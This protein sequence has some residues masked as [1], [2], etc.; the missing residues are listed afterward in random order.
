MAL[1]NQDKRVP[2]K[3]SSLAAKVVV[4]NLPE[5]TRTSLLQA[6]LKPTPV[7]EVFQLFEQRLSIS[8]PNVI[9]CTTPKSLYSSAITADQWYET[10][11][12]SNPTPSGFTLLYVTDNENNYIHQYRRHNGP[13]LSDLVKRPNSVAFYR[14]GGFYSDL[15]H[16]VFR[17]LQNYGMFNHF[18]TSGKIFPNSIVETQLEYDWILADGEK[19]IENVRVWFC[20]F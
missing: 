16:T 4:E 12:R 7:M 15:I 3:L 10:V 19:F 1:T 11:K 9:V 2:E 20:G 6:L 17:S 14:Y 13:T 5:T 8:Q 18:R